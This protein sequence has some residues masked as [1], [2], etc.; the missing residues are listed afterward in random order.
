MKQHN[1]ITQIKLYKLLLHLYLLEMLVVFILIFQNVQN[2][3]FK[4][5]PLM[6]VKIIF[7]ESAHFPIYGI[8]GEFFLVSQQIWQFQENAKFDW[9][10]IR[11]SWLKFQSAFSVVFFFWF[12]DLITEFKTP[13]NNRKLKERHLA[14]EK[15]WRDPKQ[16]IFVPRSSHQLMT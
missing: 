3:H 16:N 2:S 13:L 5:S 8:D 10:G 4:S 15:Q 14:V 1:K 12:Q 6:T 7:L 11:L 9:Y